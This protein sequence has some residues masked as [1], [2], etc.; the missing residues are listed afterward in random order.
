MPTPR[1]TS[2]HE[3]H[4]ARGL[5]I[6]SEV[7][8]SGR[9]PP[10]SKQSAIGTSRPR[11]WTKAFLSTNR[12]SSFAAIGL[13]DAA[14]SCGEQSGNVWARTACD[15]ARLELLTRRSTD[16]LVSIAMSQASASN[17][18]LMATT[19]LIIAPARGCSSTN[20]VR[21]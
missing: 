20:A 16:G 12:A 9:L 5:I 8:Q 13:R 17:S 7:A 18:S 21:A 1:M 3:G 4:A 15:G 2:C 10:I 14:T 11:T 19:H 6:Q